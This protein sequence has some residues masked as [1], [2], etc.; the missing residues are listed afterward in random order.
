MDESSAAAINNAVDI[1]GIKS[2]TAV[3]KPLRCVRRGCKDDAAP[4]IACIH[5][6][7]TIHHDCYVQAYGDLGP[8]PPDAVV[9]TAKCHARITSLTRRPGWHNDGANGPDDPVTSER[10]LLDWLTEEGNYSKYR[11]KNNN[12]VSKNKYAQ[13]IADIMNSKG[14]RVKRDAKLVVNKIAG[15]ED[16]FKN[17]FD[18]ANSETGAGLMEQGALGSFEAAVKAR[19]TFYYDLLPIMK[20]RSS[21]KPKCTSEELD[22]PEEEPARNTKSQPPLD[23]FYETSSDDSSLV[24]TEFLVP[25]RHVNTPT[26]PSKAAVSQIAIGAGSVARARKIP[27]VTRS[28]SGTMSTTLSIKKKAAKRKGEFSFID[29][30]DAERMAMMRVKKLEAASLEND[31]LAL[32][33]QSKALRAKSEAMDFRMKNIERLET[34]RTK[35]PQLTRKEII[36]WMPDLK[37]AADLVWKEEAVGGG[38]SSDNIEEFTE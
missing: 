14:V 31:Q 9:C 12:G 8:L 38:E 35:F 20:D 5:C 37:D 27:S 23:I 19:C 15:L 36:D 34:M 25:P 7:R 2:T 24:G 3:A 17:A 16:S 13:R 26:L 29:P 33:T 22:D 10:I 6:K 28:D 30:D 11:G 21:A 4:L 32:E 18:F 1:P